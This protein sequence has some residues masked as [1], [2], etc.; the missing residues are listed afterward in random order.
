VPVILMHM[1]GQPKSMQSDPQYD[2]V[3]SD[4]FAFLSERIEA[5]VSVGVAREKIIVDPGIGFG[6]RLEHN[7]ALLGGVPA[8]LKLDCPVLIGA[9]RKRCIGEL[10]GEQSP[11][12]RA[13]GSIAAVLT[14]YALGATIFRVHDVSATRQALAVAQ[15][16]QDA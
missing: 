12:D 6:K 3:V 2:D 16:L 5:S 1:L 7:V 9:S 10:T 8:L 11:A 14:T 15:A 4:V 13:A